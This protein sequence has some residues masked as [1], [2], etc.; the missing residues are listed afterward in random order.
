MYILPGRTRI[1]FVAHIYKVLP[2][3]PE[4]SLDR[5]EWCIRVR[6]ID[7]CTT[8]DEQNKHADGWNL[9]VLCERS[10]P[11]QQYAAPTTIEEHYRGISR[12]LNNHKSND[13]SKELH[14]RRVEMWVR[15]T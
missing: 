13:G 4:I 12:R 10:R 8:G 6:E 14:T 15:Q 3:Q 11:T 7:T 2:E 5:I 9:P 1:V